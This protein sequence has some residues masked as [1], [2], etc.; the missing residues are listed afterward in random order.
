MSK[1]EVMVK[2]LR[3]EDIKQGFCSNPYDTTI[4]S[5]KNNI[6]FNDLELGV[7]KLLLSSFA[8]VFFSF[9]KFEAL[10]EGVLLDDCF[11]PHDYLYAFIMASENEYLMELFLFHMSKI[12][13]KA[14]VRNIN[15]LAKGVRV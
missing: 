11:V 9:K 6:A 15:S 14:F 1:V 12:C 5:I 13:P 7:Q 3:I 8:M 4:E 10:D 2:S